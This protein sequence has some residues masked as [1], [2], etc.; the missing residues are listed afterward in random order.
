MRRFLPWKRFGTKIREKK[1][2]WNNK[3]EDDEKISRIKLILWWL[4]KKSM[5][6]I[7]IFPTSFCSYYQ[8]KC[9]QAMRQKSSSIIKTLRLSICSSVWIE[10]TFSWMREK[11][12]VWF[13]HISQGRQVK[14]VSMLPRLSAYETNRREIFKKYML[15]R[16]RLLT[17]FSQC[18][19]GKRKKSVD[20]IFVV[21]ITICQ[22]R[23]LNIYAHFPFDFH[24]MIVDVC[25]RFRLNLRR[26]WI[27]K[28]S[29]SPLQ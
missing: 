3:N 9:F 24:V 26:G 23:T 14:F 8:A 27:F 11:M 4:K 12:K 20:V 7:V 17:S 21:I 22:S 29:S 15:L 5:K 28:I 16:F 18:G 19:R 2:S 6:K 13:N 10:F 25:L 1:L